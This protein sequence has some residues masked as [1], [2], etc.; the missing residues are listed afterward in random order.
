MNNKIPY[1]YEKKNNGQCRKQ[2]NYSFDLNQDI[3]IVGQPL[4][5][6]MIC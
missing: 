2:V 4:T 1:A 3:S 5:G 6:R